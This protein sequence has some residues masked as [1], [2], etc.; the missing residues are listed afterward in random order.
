MEPLTWAKAALHKFTNNMLDNSSSG[1]KVVSQ[2]TPNGT[3]NHMLC[4]GSEEKHGSRLL[5]HYSKYTEFWKCLPS[6]REHFFLDFGMHRHM[7]CTAL[8][9]FLTHYTSVNS[10]SDT[11]IM[12]HW[13]T[14]KLESATSLQ[15]ISLLHWIVAASSVLKSPVLK[16]SLR[17]SS[18]NYKRHSTPWV[19]SCWRGW[20]RT[21]PQVHREMFRFLCLMKDL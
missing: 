13:Q 20:S 12:R 18:A 2:H 16:S 10:F 7:L 15:V 11:L 9:S 5:S 6:H 19:E 8:T 3:T 21:C 1:P 17:T 14:N 4:T